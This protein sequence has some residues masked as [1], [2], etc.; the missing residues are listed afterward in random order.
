MLPSFDSGE[1]AFGIGGPDE[2]SWFG[3]CFCDEAVDGRLEVVDGL[4]HAAPE[5]SFGELG[6]VA[7]NGIEPRS[8]SR[9]EVEAPAGMLLEPFA[10][11]G[12]FVSGIVSTMAWIA[13]RFGT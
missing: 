8:R 4:E 11:L 1:Y 13:F 3:V 12:V 7:L 5:A 6:E 2:G 9:G 10:D